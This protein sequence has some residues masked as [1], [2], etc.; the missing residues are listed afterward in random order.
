[1]IKIIEELDAASNILQVALDRYLSVCSA[2]KSCYTQINTASCVPRELSHRV[3]DEVLL[4]ASYET[5]IKEAKV[6]LSLSSNSFH[7]NVPINSLP[8]EILGRIFHLVLDAQPSTIDGPQ[9]LSLNHI[10]ICTLVCSR[11]RRI[12]VSL[13][14]LWSHIELS[15]VKSKKR[16]YDRAVVYVA[17]AGHTPLS[18]HISDSRNRGNR[19]IPT[20]TSTTQ[21]LASIAPR[22]RSLT[23]RSFRSTCFLAPILGACLANCVPGVLTRLAF[24]ISA[25]TARRFLAATEDQSMPGCRP[26]N[27]VSK[28]LLEN[29]LIHTTVLQ[30]CGSYPLWTSK[31]YHGLTTLHLLPGSTEEWYIPEQQLIE[32]LK[33]SPQLRIFHFGLTISDPR[34][35][36]AVVV[37]THLECL[38]VLVWESRDSN[39]P[40][41]FFRLIAPGLKP[42]RVSIGRVDKEDSVSSVEIKEFFARSNLTK[43][44]LS[45]SVASGLTPSVLDPL[46]PLEALVLDYSKGSTPA[47]RADELIPQSTYDPSC[48][49]NLYLIRSQTHIAE[50]QRVIKRHSVET[51]TIKLG[52]VTSDSNPPGSVVGITEE[53]IKETLRSTC[54]AVKYT[55]SGWEGELEDW[56]GLT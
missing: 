29:L 22:I 10:D 20:C 47:Y 48:F 8:D 46:P 13:G 7:N 32:M 28:Q 36:N 31:A 42:L 14:T 41:S 2:L 16:S 3:T 40:G 34:P 6:T 27:D 55:Y 52:K 44:R 49:K 18:V 38:E 21:F 50:I 12:S 5:R 53:E 9:P 24:N 17:R 37:P 4:A 39:Q 11:W 23:F 51:L 19:Y 43:L 33:S 1:M 30:L 26:I 56:I 15:P 45:V 54:P 25:K 35:A